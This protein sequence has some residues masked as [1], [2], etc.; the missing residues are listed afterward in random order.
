MSRWQRCFLLWASF[1]LASSW[2]GGCDSE[3]R[4]YSPTAKA[5]G[6]S[7]HGRR[8]AAGAN[9]LSKTSKRAEASTPA[10]VGSWQGHYT[11]QKQN[12]ALPKGESDKLWT[13]DNGSV[14]VGEGSIELSIDQSRLIV[15]LAR[16]PL[17]QL[18]L[19]GL[20]DGNTLRAGLSAAD[21]TATVTMTGFMVGEIAGDQIS[22]QLQVSNHDASLVRN[23]NV[24]L[25]RR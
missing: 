11:A 22:G 2:L 5:A 14:A 3:A 17:G 21:P 16:G 10:Y 25:R 23:A 12:L 24:R 9:S 13:P 4:Q 6:G 1:C 19:R 18:H 8:S 7:S 20:L 15:G